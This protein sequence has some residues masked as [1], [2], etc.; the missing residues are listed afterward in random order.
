MMR[1]L[2]GI[3]LVLCVGNTAA[4]AQMAVELYV[5]A[6][7]PVVQVEKR[8]DRRNFLSLPSLTFN[9]EIA[10]KCGG[11]L[12]P[13]VLSLSVADTRRSFRTDDISADENLTIRFAVP[14]AQI[15]PIPVERFC[16]HAPT[17]EDEIDNKV[18]ESVSMTVPAVLSLQAALLCASETESRIT[19]ASTPLD[20][21]LECSALEID[22]SDPV[23]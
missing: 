19:Y 9:L 5:R 6:D 16:A 1:R 3:P 14:A 10:K 11:D 12:K 17:A 8:V 7:T 13:S 22:D 18:D 4:Q 15:G 21:T 2:C 20:V 23:D